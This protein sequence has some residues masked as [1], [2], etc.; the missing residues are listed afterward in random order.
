MTQTW[1]RGW[2]KSL[3]KP[4]VEST[5][6]TGEAGDTGSIPVWS[7]RSPWRRAWQPTPVF[8]PGESHGQSSLEVYSPWGRKESETTERLNN[9]KDHYLI[10]YT[11]INSKW[12]KDLN[13][14]PEAMKLL[15]GNMG[16]VL[17]DI[18]LSSTFLDLSLQGREA[19][20]KITKI[21]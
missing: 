17:F 7:G 16:S 8:L 18:N 11:T 12:H 2:N 9:H 6:S 5:C 14:K 15:I 20:A 21:D 19:K 4:R 3:G 13:V 10:P 1:D